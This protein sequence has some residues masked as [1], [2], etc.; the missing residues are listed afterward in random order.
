MT[1]SACGGGGG[2]EVTSGQP[3]RFAVLSA[4]PA[5]GQPIFDQ[6]VVQSTVE[7]NGQTFRI[8][9]LGG[10]QVITGLTGIGLANAAATT[11]ALLDQFDVTGIVV[12]AVAG[13]NQRIGDVVVPA[14]WSLSDGSTFTA[15]ALWFGLASDLEAHG[16]LALDNCTLQPA[17]MTKQIC[18]PFAPLVLVGGKGT[19]TDGTNGS[20]AM[21]CQTNPS[22]PF[23]D[24]FGCDVAPEDP[25]MGGVSTE[26][27]APGGPVAIA[28][29]ASTVSDMET[30]AIAR[31]ATKRG[32]PFIAFRATS[33][34]AGDPL[35][36]PGFPT[37]FFVYYRLAAHNAAAAAI[38]FVEHFA[39]AP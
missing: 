17:D 5:E 8:G 15:H 13:S 27:V 3:P 6:E 26:P 7:I 36:L 38:A 11:G 35:M 9:T 39:G 37:Q 2:G 29:S 28:A 19:S 12:S 31:E 4:F 25:S 20:V 24:V 34:G 18:L 10:V 30:A 22:P 1:V 16:K 32:V 23:A 33:D 14:T 21:A